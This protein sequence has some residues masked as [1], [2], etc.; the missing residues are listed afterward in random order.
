MLPIFAEIR[1][2]LVIH[3]WRQLTLFARGAISMQKNNA[4]YPAGSVA[5]LTSLFA[6]SGFH[7]LAIAARA[8]GDDADRHRL[9]TSVDRLAERQR[10]RHLCH[11]RRQRV[12]R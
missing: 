10:Q 9:G 3:R 1:H 8:V 4:A 2:L 5:V 7:L 11:T 12:A 6:S